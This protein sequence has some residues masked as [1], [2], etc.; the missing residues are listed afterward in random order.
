MIALDTIAHL[1]QAHPYLVLF[2]LS[3]IEGPIVT[4][5]AAWLL[6]DSLWDLAGVTLICIAGD[7]LGDVALYA[8]GRRVPGMSAKWR[9]RLH[10][11]DDR[12]ARMKA[13]FD[14]HGVVTIAL[15]KLTHSAGFAVLLAA[16]AV[17]MPFGRFFMW[18]LVATLPKTLAFVLVGYA[19]GAAYGAVDAWF[20]RLTLVSLAV[21][22]AAGGF[23]L[24]H[25]RNRNSSSCPTR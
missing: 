1:I 13:H 15:G 11:T 14:Q 25:H 2:P 10:M 23:W 6:R 17:H 24:L 9:R 8:L 21:I 22:L 5:I 12:I 7:L 18:N 4:V 3:V 19:F 16:G 20:F